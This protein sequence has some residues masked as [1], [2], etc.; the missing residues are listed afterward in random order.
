MDDLV[1]KPI[2]GT[3]RSTGV[4]EPINPFFSP[5]GRWVGFRQGYPEGAPL[6]KIPISGGA[7]VTLCECG[8]LNPSASWADDG[9][10]VFAGR[11]GI[12]Q[13]MADGGKE[14]LL[15]A[16]N[17]ENRERP[18]GPQVLPGGEAVL[19]TLLAGGDEAQIVVHSLDTGERKVLVN[20]GMDA[21]YVPT[22]HVVYARGGTL[23]AVTF[24]VGSLAIGD[25]PVPILEGIQQLNSASVFSFSSS[26]SLVYVPASA[27]V[28][29]KRQ[30]IWVDR[31]GREEPVTEEPRSYRWPRVSPDGQHLAV[32]IRESGNSDVWI[33]D[34]G[35]ETWTPLTFDPGND[36]RP[37]WTPDGRRVVFRSQRDAPGL[38]WKAADG[39]GTAKRLTTTPDGFAWS[40]SPDGSRL[41]FA[42]S[43]EIHMLSME[44]ERSS[45]ALFAT[46][47]IIQHAMISPDG[48]WVA[49]TSNETGNLEVYV[50]PFPDVEEGKR[51]ISRGGGREPVWSPQGRELFYESFPPGEMM[52]VSIETERAFT[53]GSPKLLFTGIHDAGAGVG[54]QHDIH[55]DGQRF[56]MLKEVGTTEE[57][58]QEILVVQNWFEELRR[59]VPT[60]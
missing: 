15:I 35:R 57:T 29:T 26:G 36:T 31:E 53:Y 52:A 7:P 8:G 43:R 42:D 44:G 40:F 55:P 45:K 9:R 16:V 50:Q 37:M 60:E 14:E 11:E 32:E 30:L 48:Q 34:L 38:Y 41:L 1:A 13:V 19:F 4:E 51:Q 49:Y 33:Y 20:G 58:Q 27:A 18:Y 10:I 23:F 47:S 24:D 39:S 28:E 59:L 2:A 5:D 22:G 54:R 56:L 25:A 21:R 12:F 17:S 6:K 3:G 46:G